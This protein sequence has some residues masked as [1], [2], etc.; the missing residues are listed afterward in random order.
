MSLDDDADDDVGGGGGPL[1]P[2][3]RLWRHPSELSAWAPATPPRSSGRAS[4]WPVAAVASLVGAALCG[5]ALVVAG[6]LRAEEGQRVVEKVA[7]T[8][9]VSSPLV[10]GERGVASVVE[11]TSPSV[12]Q[13]LVRTD[14]GPAR[15]TAVVWRDDGLLL[16]SAHAIAAAT[17]LTVVL[18]DGR[19]LPGTVLGV[20]L[21]TDVAV[22]SIEADDLTVA[23]LGSSAGL[24]VGTPT[25]A[26][27]SP[28]RLGDPTMHTGVV[29]ALQR[30]LDI[31][32]RSLH[33]LIQTD[34]PIQAGWPGGPLVDAM[35][36][37]VGIT[38]DSGGPDTSSGFATPID[39][40]R[41]TAEALLASGRVSHAWLGIEGADLSDEAAERM[42]VP[43]GAVVRHVADGSPAARSGLTAD[44]VITSLG[45][46]E[47]LSSS[48]LVVAM[49][50]HVPGDRVM[51][52]YWRNGQPHEAMVTVDEL[53]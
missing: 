1:H 11:H 35:G 36:A 52:G 39:L 41:R 17:D 6:T 19:R 18:H 2:D 33:G 42:A 7:L 4:T 47:V 27:G 50:D 34:A 12:A 16:T 3:D 22:L 48:G 28:A 9:V 15:A 10:G 14:A 5:G 43:G 8:P 40:V 25:I 44:D 23:V 24:S 21:P 29:S 37:V 30:R 53:P 32:G 45:E 31:D 26:I 49:R 13:V 51:V 46:D 20:D 38:T